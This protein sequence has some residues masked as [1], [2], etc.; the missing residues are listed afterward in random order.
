MSKNNISRRAFLRLIGIGG[1]AV[2]AGSAW[3]KPL[4]VDMSKGQRVEP[5]VEA[6]EEEREWV[7]PCTDKAEPDGECKHCPWYFCPPGYRARVHAQKWERLWLEETRKS[8]VPSRG[9]CG[10]VFIIDGHERDDIG[11]DVA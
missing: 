9:V 3:I 1:A 11:D 10:R 2:A 5:V 8:Y 6:Q 4:P 7:H